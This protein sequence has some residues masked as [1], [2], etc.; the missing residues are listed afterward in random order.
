M[1]LLA[2]AQQKQILPHQMYDN[3]KTII[4]LFS[5]T[6]S[7]SSVDAGHPGVAQRILSVKLI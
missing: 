2:I 5:Q 3:K 7:V 4:R 1:I 6:I